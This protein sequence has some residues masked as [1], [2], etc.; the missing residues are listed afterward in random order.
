MAKNSGDDVNEAVVKVEKLNFSYIIRNGSSRNFKQTV[1][2]LKKYWR[3]KVTIEA[4][5]DI[6]FELFHGDTLAVVG[7]NG[8]GKSTLL[9]IL[10]GILPPNSGLVQVNGN[11]APLIELGAGF[12]PDLTGE[13]NIVLF[14]VLLGNSTKFMK[15]NVNKIADWAGIQDYLHL[16]LRV[17]STGMTA[18]LGFAVATFVESDLIFVDELLSVGDSHFQLKSFTKI[19]ELIDNGKVTILVSHDLNIVRKISNKVLWLESGKQKAFG[20]TSEVL[21]LYEQD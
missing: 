1:L 2:H 5:N 20:P 21:E 10:T 8:S 12:H 19:R 9:K 13:E 15:R 16:P 17:Y 3:R 18:K 6:S 14:G 7:S 4:L 11:I